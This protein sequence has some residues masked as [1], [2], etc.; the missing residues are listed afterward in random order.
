M[1]MTGNVVVEEYL[2]LGW[3][4]N[5]P[6]ESEKGFSEDSVGRDS[7]SL[8]IFVFIFYSSPSYVVCVLTVRTVLR[9]VDS[10]AQAGA[11]A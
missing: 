1:Y 8:E 10:V 2:L 4:L 11:R 5:N 9:A 7:V 3:V 6:E